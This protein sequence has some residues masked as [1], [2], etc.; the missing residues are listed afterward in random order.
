[1]ASA[2]CPPMAAAT[3]SAPAAARTPGAS[4]S[5]GHPAR[6][7]R[8]AGAR[9]GCG[10]APAGSRDRRHRGRRQAARPPPRRFRRRVAR[11]PPVRARSATRPRT[12][13]RAVSARPASATGPATSGCERGR[14]ARA[15]ARTRPAS[16]RDRGH[17]DRPVLD[18]LFRRPCDVGVAQRS[19]QRVAPARRHPPPRPRTER[20]DPIRGRGP[21]SRRR[22]DPAHA[23]GPTIATTSVST[24]TA[25]R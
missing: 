1:M 6:A 4:C 23:S 7:P 21:A 16:E 2:A 25:P 19:G 5:R 22:R 20:P 24:S 12:V 13:A 10:R 3:D 14:A 15:R 9:A 18:R 11:P 8:R 17:A